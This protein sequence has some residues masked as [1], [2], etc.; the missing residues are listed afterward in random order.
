MIHASS[1]GETSSLEDR[2]RRLEDAE[3][4]LRTLYQYAE[5]LD[6]GPLELFLDCFTETATW[7]GI[8]IDLAPEARPQR[9][10]QGVAELTRYFHEPIRS[11]APDRYFKHLLV[12]PRISIEDDEARVTSYFVRIQEHRDGPY[13][14]AF[15]RYRDLLTRCDDGRWRLQERR[16]EIE[17]FQD[18][19]APAPSG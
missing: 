10:F 3:G 8:R 13:I 5:G 16:A 18:R 15:G 1:S 19:W 14:H 4:V 17:A 6:Y 12:E 9:L 11:R 2:V 7:E